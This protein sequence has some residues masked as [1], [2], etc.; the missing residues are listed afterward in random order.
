MVNRINL[1]TVLSVIPKKMNSV[2]EEQLSVHPSLFLSKLLEKYL[3]NPNNKD[4][5]TGNTSAH[6]QNIIR[7]NTFL[8]IVVFLY[9]ENH[10]VMCSLFKEANYLSGLLSL[11]QTIK[12]LPAT[13]ETQVWSPSQ[14]DPLEKGMATHSSIL[15]WR[16]PWTEEPGGL[17]FWG[18]Q[19]VQH[20]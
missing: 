8:S 10:P 11:V 14:E 3:K 5:W 4:T 19:R 2:T 13:W 7:Q 18:S 9:S 15:A 16:I 17:Q 6:P 12:N 1:F 20:H